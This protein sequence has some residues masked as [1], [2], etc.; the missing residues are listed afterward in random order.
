MAAVALSVADILIDFVALAIIA[1][2]LFFI[3]RQESSRYPYVKGLLAL[4]TVL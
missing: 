2:T 4:F 3:L 1:V